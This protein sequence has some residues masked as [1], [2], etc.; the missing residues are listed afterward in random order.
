MDAL[1]TLLDQFTLNARVFFAG[2][3]CDTSSFARQPELGAIHV[4]RGGH[5]RLDQENGE[6]VEV[7]EPAILFFA[8]PLAHKFH[9]NRQTGAELVCGWIDLGA[10]LGN[11]LLRGLP[12]LIL[13]PLASIPGI[14]ATLTMLF[15]EAFASLPG[16]QAA[17][18]RLIEYVLVLLLR[19]AMRS[20]LVAGSLLA[21]LADP[22]LSKAVVAM[23]D[24]PEQPWSVALL[25]REAGM[26]RARFA[27]HF[28][29]VTNVTPLDYLTDWRMS[30]AQRLLKRG[31]PLKLIAPRVGYASPVALARVFSQRVGV[32]PARW[33]LGSKPPR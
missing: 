13:V 8:R 10:G 11:P 2:S 24:K 20:N 14:D 4:L 19:H 29:E 22:R 21:A 7:T 18:N 26:S 28:R 15:D 32:T 9:V 17:L 16:R 5:L 25:A 27:A 12:E 1:S 31:M 23:H 33:Q 30:L 6:S 3:L